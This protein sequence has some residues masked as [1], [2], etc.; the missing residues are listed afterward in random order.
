MN[1]SSHRHAWHAGVALILVAGLAFVGC[2][3]NEPAE[4]ARRSSLDQS[5][6]PAYAT[7]TQRETVTAPLTFEE[8]ATT[9]V[10]VEEREPTVLTM[11][12]PA[13][14]P[15][16]AVIGPPP[17]P[18]PAPPPAPATRS[19]TI[20][21][22]D[23]LSQLSQTYLGTSRRWDEIVA[24]NPG[25]DPN[26]LIVGEVI[27]IPAEGPSPAAAAPTGGAP[28]GGGSTHTIAPG[29]TLSQISER[30]YGTAARWEEILEANPGVSPTRLLVGEELVI[31]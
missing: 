11:G 17:A 26:R 23:T 3:T 8:T 28:L 7:A 24:V 27:L 5:S 10:V 4:T 19:H 31:P 1:D 22:G 16:P 9:D 6:E 18:T 2:K 21:R 29:D 13:P 12:D 14:S 30:Y 20:A 15:A 25:I